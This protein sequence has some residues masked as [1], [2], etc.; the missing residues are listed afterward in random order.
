MS[1]YQVLARR[2]RPQRF[3]ELVGQEVAVRSLKNAIANK[4]VG[5]AYLFSGL[6]GV[7]KTTAARLFAKALNCEHGPTPTPCGQCVACTDIADGVAVDVV[8]MDAASTRGIDDIRDLREVARLLPIRDRYRVFILDE[9]HQLSRDAF[10]ALLKILEE[11]PAHVIFVLASTDKQKFP[12]TILSRC[13]QIDFRPVPAD[14][15][16]AHL[17]QVARVAGIALAAGAAQQIARAAAGSVR[18]GLSLLDRLHAFGGDSIDEATVAEVLGLPPTEV[19]V[20]LWRHLA[21]GNV[22][23]VLELVG[24]EDRVGHDTTA[25]YEQLVQLLHTLLLLA[26]NRNAPMPFAES[27]RSSLA[28]SAAQ[29]GIP[30][31]LRLLGLALEQ[32]ALIRNS[33]DANLAVTVALGRLALWPR[34]RQVE[35]LLA[36]GEGEVGGAVAEPSSPARPPSQGPPPWQPAGQGGEL[37]ARLV[38]ALHG[39]GY[40]A[41]AGRVATA[42]SV[43]LAGDTLF[44]RFPAAKLPTLQSVREGL[45]HLEEVVREA[46]IASAVRVEAQGAA[47]GAG[48]AGTPRERVEADERVRRVLEVFGGRI[49]SVEEQR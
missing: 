21:D 6:R 49:T 44:L 42:S 12:A 8:E 45:G 43:G 26:S 3:E 23:A 11:P 35:A 4:E 30:L 14:V 33:D 37:A 28:E 20:E 47:E 24:R 40:H 34:L 5:H 36:A 32:Q 2:F 19:L 15:I 17:G 10:S 25:L 16:A 39:A 38:E 41:L 27:Y 9:A 13:Q 31:L 22:D 1:P 29:L 46:G 18:D 7:G 48:A